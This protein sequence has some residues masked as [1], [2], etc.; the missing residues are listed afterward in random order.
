MT[1]IVCLHVC[2]CVRWC[3]CV[4]IEQHRNN[5]VKLGSLCCINMLVGDCTAKSRLLRAQVNQFADD[6]ALYDVTGTM[7]ESARR[8]LLRWEVVLV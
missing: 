4:R 6:L 7:F 5:A 8:S 1:P 3:V 2:A